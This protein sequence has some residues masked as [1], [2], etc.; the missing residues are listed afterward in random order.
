MPNLFQ[1]R[2]IYSKHTPSDTFSFSNTFREMK[3]FKIQTGFSR[4]LWNIS[5]FVFH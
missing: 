1:I 4:E 5:N 3:I 2:I